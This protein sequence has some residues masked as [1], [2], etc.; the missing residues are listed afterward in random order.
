MVTATTAPAFLPRAEL[1]RLLD[2]L[3][4]DGRR[5]IGPTVREG[6]IVYDEVTT[7]ADLPAGWTATQAPGSYRLQPTGTD[8]LFDFAVGPTSWKHETFPPRVPLT[9]GRRV[10]GQ[11]AFEDAV[12]D[13]PS[14]AFLGVRGC[15]IAALQTQ[16]AVF[17]AGPA[18][19][20]DYAARRAA[21]LVIAVECEAPAST[22]FCTSMGT[23]PR[24]HERVRPGPDRARRRLP[25]PVR[26]AGG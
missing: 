18:V 13:P 7:V 9:V 23:G 4:G 21:A 16:D 2:L 17:E 10:D 12:P 15:E 25:R 19:D 6:A 26:L 1:G 20:R 14:L 22:C 11:A 8:R 24:G 5:I 3:H